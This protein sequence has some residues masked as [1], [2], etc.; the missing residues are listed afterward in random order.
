M[1][2]AA[3]VSARLRAALSDRYRVEKEL[4]AGGM[5]TVYLAHDL[6]HER[7][8]AIKVLHPDLGAALGAERFL[9]EIKTTAKLQHPHI[10][11]LL[12]SG[13]ADGLL[14]YVMPYVRGETLRARLERETQLPVP[15]ALQIAR[16]VADA[17]QA[18]HTLGVV[19]RDIKPENILLQDGHA[20]VADFGIALALQQ[21][22]GQRITQTGLSLGTPQ[23][24]SPEQASGEKA[25]DARS[26]VYALAAVTYEMLTGG[27][28]FTGSSVQAVIAR[29][30]SSDPEPMT[31]VRRTIPPALDAAVL[32]GLAK[33]PAD[34]FES[35][36]AFADVLRADAASGQTYTAVASPPTRR[37]F[38][39]LAALVA[40]IAVVAALGGWFAA[41]RGRG[42]NST[43][44]TSTRFELP[45]A[46]GENLASVLV[47]PFLFTPDG[48]SILYIV[49]RPGGTSQLMRRRLDQLDPLPVQGANATANAAI[50]PDGK[51]LA[52]EQ[53]DDL[54]KLPVEGGARSRLA[55]T[56]RQNGIAWPTDNQIVL[57]TNANGGLRVMDLKQ[58]TIREILKPDRGRIV[59]WPIAL[60][61]E[62]AVIATVY[63]PRTDS[64]VVHR[65]S[66]PDG[67]AEPIGSPAYFPVG[68][69]KGQFVFLDRRSRLFV[70]AFDGRKVSGEPVQVATGFAMFTTGIAL[71]LVGLSP[72][73]DLVYRDPGSSSQLVLREPNGVVRP[74]SPDTQPYLH[75]RVSPDGRHVAVTVTGDNGFSGSIWV[76]DRTTGVF[77]RTIREDDGSQRDRPEWTPDGRSILHRVVQASGR[78][79]RIRNLADE[80]IDRPA[81]WAPGLVNEAVIG[82]DGVSLVGRINDLGDVAQA[83]YRWTLQ[84]TVPRRIGSGEVNPN[85]PRISAD[86]RW[87]AYNVV[88]GGVRHVFVSPFPGPGPRVQIDRD[89]AGLPMWSKD[90]KR[91]YFPTKEAMVSVPMAN[92]QPAG[93]PRVEF[94]SLLYPTLV[95]ETH[96]GFDV[97]PD[98]GFVL[99]RPI[100]PPR[101]VVVRNFGRELDAALG[102]KPK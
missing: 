97:T 9:S 3:Q 51:W 35:A 71:G 47:R 77:A 70:Q 49:S 64:A 69:R 96:A 101:N 1:S 63:D 27:P 90:G 76:L 95:D 2:D 81:S 45:L 91:L 40:G 57:G 39:P 8:V 88:E 93:E 68:V 38:I 29:V 10:L 74:L 86:G 34:R 66:I 28:P 20:L 7:D 102:E 94:E 62:S 73:G 30:L 46:P 58:G 67:K 75:P 92:G 65:I 17:L 59:N 41:S 37:T 80:G 56:G 14:Y 15:D 4:G 60:P 82:P 50:S 48:N 31:R 19:H 23:Y 11:P 44:A 5:A 6:R 78:Q 33:L 25:V 84:D 72:L 32:R 85:G 53:G 42:D 99:V 79:Y 83:L 89:G 54:Y 61:G 52:I 18:A 26:D 12:D 43:S 98:G 87:L 16:E 13:A 22:G 100:R 55:N 21:A 24:M 36:R